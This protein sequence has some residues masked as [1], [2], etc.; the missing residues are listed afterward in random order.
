MLAAVP[1]LVPVLVPGTVLAVGRVRGV[2]TWP[3]D[4]LEGRAAA[5]RR[6][7]LD[8]VAGPDELRAVAGPDELR[9][10][11]GPD[12]LRA[13]AGP[14]E[15]RAVACPDGLPSG[16]A[17]HAAEGRGGRPPAAPGWPPA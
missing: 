5:V 10:V 14:D 16:A 13:V 8:G 15:L 9:A 1:V 2:G 7:R 11:A 6:G 3:G 12:E 17:D 4:R